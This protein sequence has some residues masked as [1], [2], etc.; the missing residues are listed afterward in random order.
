MVVD[1]KTTIYEQYMLKKFSKELLVHQLGVFSVVLA[2]STFE[3]FER[4]TLQ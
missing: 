2:A 1:K 3:H 4:L